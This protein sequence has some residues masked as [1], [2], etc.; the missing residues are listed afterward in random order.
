VKYRPRLVDTR[1]AEV[2]NES[3]AVMIL[4]PRGVG[5]STTA[6]RYADSVYRLDS[7]RDS[8]S[9]RADPDAAIRRLEGCALID[10]WQEVPEVLWAVKRAVDDGAPA[11]SFILTGSVTPR[12]D[13][14]PTF[15]RVAPLTMWPAT[16]RERIGSPGSQTTIER[17]FADDC[18]LPPPSRHWTVDHYVDAAV[19]G[20][21][22]A[23]AFDGRSAGWFTGYISD[24]IET[25]QHALSPRMDVHR[26][27]AWLRAVAEQNS[28]NPTEQTLLGAVGVNRR[29][30]QGYDDI[31]E[32]M[33]IQDI[34]HSWHSSRF[35]RLSK[36]PKRYL[37]DTGL[38]AALI[39][40]T[41][42]DALVDHQI[43]GSLLDALV[44]QE[45]RADVSLDPNR[46]ELHFLRDQNGRT[47]V[48]ILI[49]R[50]GRVVAI[51]VT[52]SVSGHTTRHLEH[53][54]DTLGDAFHHGFILNTGSA[55]YRLGDRLTAA[56]IASLW[57]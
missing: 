12:G 6:A 3:P 26:F 10:E 2:L 57:N 52:S 32:A 44:A 50:A 45:L 25:A 9:F 39:N 51:E 28:R 49:V 37:T 7:P 20:G 48:D 34:V 21:F 29:T 1:L 16:M 18:D 22:P 42:A 56:P 17:L 41:A 23:V 36:T 13:V 11:G 38:A 31:L 40:C 24:L 27:R 55:A 47:E 8:A 19:G 5:K 43:T 30:G 4:G 54:R 33:F 53:L 46:P 15:G 35:K 14:K